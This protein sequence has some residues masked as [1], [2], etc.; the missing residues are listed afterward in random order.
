M[1][2]QCAVVRKN[3]NNRRNHVAR[4]VGSKTSQ[5]RA[6]ADLLQRPHINVSRPQRTERTY[7]CSHVHV[8][9]E[10]YSVRLSQRMSRPVTDPKL[11]HTHSASPSARQRVHRLV[12][13]DSGRGHCHTRSIRQVRAAK[14]S[15][16]RVHTACTHALIMARS[17]SLAAVSMPASRLRTR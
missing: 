14:L 17:P 13:V 16:R 7:S 4:R 3:K 8:I 2:V 12:G 9:G 11:H 5:G 10:V 15:R 6:L 1:P